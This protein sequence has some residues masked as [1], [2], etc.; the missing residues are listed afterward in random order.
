[1][2]IFQPKHVNQKLKICKCFDVF[3]KVKKFFLGIF[4]FRQGDLECPL[5]TFPCV[6]NSRCVDADNW[7]DGRIHCNDAS[8]ENQCKCK[9]RIDKDKLCDGYYDCPRGEDELG[10]F[11]KR[12]IP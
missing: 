1:M 2:P 11:G 6:D 12:P 9:E 4:I 3:H 5:K 8:D 10:C 7:C